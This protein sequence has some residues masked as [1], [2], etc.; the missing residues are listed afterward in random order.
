MHPKFARGVEVEDDEIARLRL[1]EEWF[2]N[3]ARALFES[4]EDFE[5]IIKKK[6]PSDGLN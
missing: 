4:Q 3:E 1:A 6:T 5:V 2:I